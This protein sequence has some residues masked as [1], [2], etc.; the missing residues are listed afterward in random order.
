MSSYNSTTS[1]TT[2]G[3]IC[4]TTNLGPNQLVYNGEL[5]GIAIGLEL[6]TTLATPG[7]EVRAFADNQAALYRLATPSDRPGQA[8]QLRCIKAAN[9]LTN[10][11]CTVSL[12]WVPG[13]QDILGNVS[14]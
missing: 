1:T 4:R 11:G 5:E 6:A 12:S 14:D 7:Q 10:I 3:R 2:P 8:W 9:I 13:H